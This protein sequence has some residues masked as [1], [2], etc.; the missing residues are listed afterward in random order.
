MSKAKVLARASELNVIVEQYKCPLYKEWNVDL[1]CES[2]YYFSSHGT[3]WMKAWCEQNGPDWKH[4]LA[5]LEEGNVEPCN[6]EDC[7]LD[8]QTK[9][10]TG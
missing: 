9:E 10:K 6:C 1:A 4:I 8:E 7:K 2:G 3:H 5:E